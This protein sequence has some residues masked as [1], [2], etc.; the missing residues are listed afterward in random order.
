MSEYYCVVFCTTYL[1][2]FILTTSRSCNILVHVYIYIFMN[3]EY[4]MRMRIN[5]S[6]GYKKKSNVN[7]NYAFGLL[8]N[9]E[10]MSGSPPPSGS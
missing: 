9:M 7:K 3:Y 8:T 5:P 4:S 2:V 1:P 10:G 6:R